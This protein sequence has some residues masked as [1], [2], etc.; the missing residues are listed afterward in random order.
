MASF[1]G[2]NKREIE[3]I[4]LGAQL[5]DIGKIALRDDILFNPRKLSEDDL[6]L[7]RQHPRTGSS[8]LEHIPYLPSDILSVVFLHHEQP[9]GQGYPSGLGADEIPRCAG[10]TATG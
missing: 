10:I 9:D 2:D 3:T 6:A 7:Y 8:I 5:H 1:A 4:A